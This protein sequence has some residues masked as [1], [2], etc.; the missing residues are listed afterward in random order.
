MSRT[1]VKHVIAVHIR[2]MV[3]RKQTMQMRDVCGRCP[4]MIRFS[5]SSGVMILVHGT[6]VHAGGVPINW[7]FTFIISHMSPRAHGGKHTIIALF[8]GLGLSPD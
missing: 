5:Y 8:A 3:A 6:G 1:P 4:C 2:P 7:T